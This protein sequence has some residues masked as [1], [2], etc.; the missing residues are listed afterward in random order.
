MRIGNAILT[1]AFF[2]LVYASSSHAQ[3]KEQLNA[4]LTPDLG[5][6][7][8]NSTTPTTLAVTD[9]PSAA[10]A[11][12]PAPQTGGGVGGT[13]Q[14]D[15]WHISVSPYLWF[16]GVHGTVGAFG[17]DVGFKASPTDLLSNFRFGLMGAVEARRNRIVVP[18][19]LMWIRLEDDRAVP[20]PNLL[21][22]SAK[23]TATEFILTPKIGLRLINEKKIKADFLTGFR[24][25]HFGEGLSFN[26]SRFGL[27]F[28][29]SQNWVDP[30]VGGR[31]EVGLSPKLVANILGDVGGWGT[32]SQLEYQIAGLLGYKVKPK[33]TL[34]AGY[35][36]LYVDYQKGGQAAAI[37]IAAT[38]GIVIGATLSLK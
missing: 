33:I 36:Y 19:D 20:F 8:A 37:A 15:L 14:D 23:L 38:S 30:L 4:S 11:P 2:V 22:T 32:G 6:T 5:V 17:R 9:E 35:R 24:Y 27:N 31:I 13:D 25:W 18:I 7:Y 21:A 34:Q 10:P 28:S 16:P 26:P 12:G 29:K 3:R 1:S